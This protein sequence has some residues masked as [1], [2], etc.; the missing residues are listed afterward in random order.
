MQKEMKEKVVTIGK[1]QIK[2][3]CQFIGI[4]YLCIRF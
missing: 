3:L 1:K 4:L 2:N